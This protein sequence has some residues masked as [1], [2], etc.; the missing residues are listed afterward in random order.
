MFTNIW[1]DNPDEDKEEMKRARV[2]NGMADSILRGLGIG[3]AGVATIKNILLKIKSESNKSQPDYNKAAMEVFD[4][5][6]PID[7]KIR[8][9]N[10]TALSFKYDKKDM[11]TMGLMDINNPAYLAGAN[12]ISAA[13]NFP[14]DRMVKKTQNMEGVMTDEMEMWQRIARFS[15][16]SQWEIGPFEPKPIKKIKKIR[17]IKKKK[18]KKR[19]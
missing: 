1:E 15:G 11:K 8:K 18:L 16:W 4:F 12:V 6:P 17:K 14:I 13:T 3:G 5:I 10:Q 19:V 7:S 9:L 2:A